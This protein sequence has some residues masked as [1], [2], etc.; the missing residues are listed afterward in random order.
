MVSPG[1][2]AGFWVVLS[3]RAGS[4]KGQLK[5]RRWDTCGTEPGNGC[6]KLLSRDLLPCAR[7]M[8]GTGGHG[9]TDLGRCWAEQIFAHFGCTLS[10]SSTA[11]D[12]VMEQGGGKGGWVWG[13]RS[14]DRPF[15]VDDPTDCGRAGQRTG[16][17]DEAYGRRHGSKTRGKAARTSSHSWRRGGLWGARERLWSVPGGGKEP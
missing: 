16:P 9:A 12:G 8:D 1:F 14:P 10:E 11:L 17:R 13:I 5:A 4:S 2:R 3:L 6:V 15:K 7:V